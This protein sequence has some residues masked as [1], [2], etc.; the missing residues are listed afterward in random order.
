MKDWYQQSMKALDLNG[1]SKTTQELYTRSVRQL[2]DFYKKTPDL[3]TEKE[4]EDYFLHR[5]K[6]NLWAPSTMGICYSGIKFFF[7]KGIEA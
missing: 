3:I 6:H 4:L 5:K 1:M 7:P 2:V